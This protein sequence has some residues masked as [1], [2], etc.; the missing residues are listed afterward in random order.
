MSGGGRA[1]AAPDFSR[2]VLEDLYRY[3]R[4]SKKLAVFFWLFTGILGGHRFYLERPGTALAMALT[5]GGGLLWWLIDGWFVGRMVTAIN[6]DQARRE[7]EGLPPIALAFMPPVHAGGLP[8]EPAWL[9][10]RRG[11]GRFK[12]D[13]LL[14][15]FAGFSAGAISAAS[16][17]YEPVVVIFALGLIILLGAR[18]DALAHIPLLR[19][20]DRWSHRLRLYYYV[21]DPGGPLRLLFRPILGLATAP[22]RRRARAE[23]WLYL[24][25]GLWFTVLFTGLDLFQAISLSDDGIAFDFASF[26]GDLAL[27]LAVIYGFAAPI[28]AVLTT[29]IL[30]EKRDALVWLLCVVT[31]VATVFGM[32]TVV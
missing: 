14:L 18:W 30:L 5:A 23:A 4:K 10:R 31:F 28:G 25:P 24:Q 2:A 32:L 19:G 9:A 15:I 29:Q 11:H 20:F 16:G 6:A 3:P 22:F 27:T 17:N 26:I 21:N 1:G 8:A 12:A 13:L 7:R